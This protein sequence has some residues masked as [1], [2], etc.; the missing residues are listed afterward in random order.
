MT[1]TLEAPAAPARARKLRDYQLEAVEAIRAKWAAGVSNPAI[2]MAT[3]LGKTDV[4]ARVAV[5]EVAAQAS[6]EVSAGGRVL[7]LVNRLDLVEQIAGRIKMHAPAL[8]VGIVG[9]GKFS[10]RR[11]VTVAMAQ[12]LKTDKRRRQLLRPTLVIVDECHYAASDGF[13]KIL[14]W[15]GCFAEVNPTRLLGV[16]ATFTRGTSKG[17]Q[18][19]DVFHVEAGEDGRGHVAFERDIAF[20]IREGYLVEP[21]GRCVVG[22]H[23]DVDKVKT[24]SKGDYA[25]NEL[26][27]MVAQ[28]VDRIVEAWL[29]HAADRVTVAFTP[30][31]SSAAALAAAF[32]RVGVPVG[33][34]Y[35]STPPAE[36]GSAEQGTGI[37]GQLARGE[38][39]VLVSVMVPTTGWDCPPVSCVLNARP[40]K[41]LGLYTQMIGRGL[42]LLDPAE[43]PGHEPKLDCLVLD[44]V[45]AAKGK[46]LR[47]LVDLHKGAKYDDTDLE[48]Q[49][50][51]TCYGFL[52]RPTAQVL[53]A[54]AARGM[55]ACS[56]PCIDCGEVGNPCGC[57]PLE[58]DPDG[59]RQRLRGPA[60]YADVNL[61]GTGDSEWNWQRTP[62]GIEFLSVGLHL[63][64]LHPEGDGTFSAGYCEAVGYGPGVDLLVGVDLE[65]ARTAAEQFVEERGG[66]PRDAPWR[67]ARARATPQQQDV[68]RRYGIADPEGYTK[69]G[70]SDAIDMAR[71]VRRF[72]VALAASAGASS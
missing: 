30:S 62:G 32:R 14:E 56:C 52:G 60:I 64:A 46:T 61:L 38:L 4:I 59:G 13:Y 26:G 42:R 58:R 2:V 1:A 8:P 19:A 69:G 21:I 44:V 72:D 11:P 3:G 71:A 53:A 18:L 66:F 47:I 51:T 55:V 20:G 15:A 9:D 12:T 24:N 63:V 70:I 40:T 39:R 43:Y 34:V 5:D 28:D 27:D 68:A 67:T 48:L 50:C 6:A 35:G 37:Y 65:R 17:R 49:P 41:L 7:V 29:E 45:G 23:V 31:V 54:A 33:E 22:E 36:R 57:A 10:G 16:T 25:D